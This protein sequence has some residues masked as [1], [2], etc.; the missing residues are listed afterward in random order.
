MKKRLFVAI[1]CMILVVSMVPAWAF[2]EGSGSMDPG[3]YWR[4]TRLSQDSEGHVIFLPTDD[5][6]STKCIEGST[7]GSSNVVE[8][9]YVDDNREL[10]HLKFS[11][12]EFHGDFYT[13]QPMPSAQED[14]SIEN[15]DN[16][17]LVDINF[18]SEDYS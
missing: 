9:F 1:L 4:K 10:H 3:L 6:Y 8:F 18:S 14:S 5:E 2:A 11:D 16:W 13:A 17:S 12:L 7:G 15:K